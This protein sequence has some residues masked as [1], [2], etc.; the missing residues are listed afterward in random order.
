MRKARTRL[1]V[2]SGYVNGEQAAFFNGTTEYSYLSGGTEP[3]SSSNTS[4]FSFEFRTSSS[5]GVLWWESEWIGSKSNDFLTIHLRK[6]RVNVAV[7]F[8]NDTLKS[9]TT[10]L[11]VVNGKWHRVAVERREHRTTVIID[12]KVTTIVSSPNASRLNT[13]GLVYIGYGGLVSLGGIRQKGFN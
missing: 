5:N 10:N 2:A 8:G 12:D 13:N 3:F 1:R 9:V 11:A 4:K 7:N 6:G